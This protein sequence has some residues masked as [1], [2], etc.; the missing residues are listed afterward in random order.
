MWDGCCGGGGA[1]VGPTASL[2]H[3]PCGE[4]PQVVCGHLGTAPSSCLLLSP[5]LTLLCFHKWAKHM[6]Q[7][8]APS[9]HLQ[10]HL[11]EEGRENEV[12]LVTSSLLL[13]LKGKS[14]LRLTHA[15]NASIE[16]ILPFIIG[17]WSPLTPPLG[18]HAGE[19][20]VKHNLFPHCTQG[21][22]CDHYFG[23]P[24]PKRGVCKHNL[25]A[26]SRGGGGACSNTNS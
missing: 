18:P 11:K 8:V 25:L 10:E 3:L 14:G 24:G 2:G 23:Q 12:L 1:A 26:G 9:C 15:S 17:H 20:P 5:R 6:V 13:H 7:P 22:G 19:N 21:Q 4:N 16:A